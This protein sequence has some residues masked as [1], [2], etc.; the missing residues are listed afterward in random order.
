MR[1]SE[2]F[3]R[4]QA[5]YC[6]RLGVEVGIFVAVDHLRR[7][8]LLTAR[9]EADYLDVDDWFTEHLPNPDFYG[10]GNTVGAVTWFHA[11]VPEDMQQR[12][13]RLCDILRAHG[14]EFDVVHSTDPGTVVYQDEFQ[15]GVVPRVRREAT[16]LPDG[17]V[18][19]PTTPGSKRAVAVSPIRH[20]LFDADDVLQVVPGGW[21]A[22]AAPV[23]GDRAREFVRRAWAVERPTLAGV[24]DFIPLL[25]E[26]VAEFGVSAPVEQVFADI[27]C[28]IEPVAA[29]FEVVDALRRNGYG[30]H[31][32]TNQDGRRAAHMRDV[33]GYDAVF[34]T[35][36]Y[37]YDLG[38]AKPDPAFFTEAARRI[39]ADPATI[40]FVDD[41]LAN[42]EGA[43]AAGLVAE[44]WTVADGTPVLIDLLGAHGVDGRA[45]I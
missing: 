39:D 4:V 18:L 38:V 44:R 27:W 30:V 36:C 11:P 41:T 42:V 45:T 34:G 20:V 25:A 8:G 29:S 5:T 7:A 3:V 43:R 10:D 35:S 23:V 28:R 37:S 21:E 16:P 40:L 9:E 26:V 22:L 12:V 17:V 2:T 13:D 33:L 14:V 31:L 24:G 19:A 32:R 6:G 15:V 1:P